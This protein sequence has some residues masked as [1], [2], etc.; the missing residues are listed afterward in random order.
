MSNDISLIGLLAFATLLPFLVA[1]GTCYLKFSI[2]FVIVGNALALQQVP[3]NL[4]V[5]AVA[6]MMSIFEMMPVVTSVYE[7]Q[8]EHPV[9]FSNRE[10]VREFLD[11]G[12]ADYR[13]YLQKHTDPKLTAFFS[14]IRAK[15]LE[16]SGD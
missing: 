2:V 13:N 10:S 16:E 6:L 8:L 11:A 12:L 4:V 15:N 3:S 1:A 14:N 9:N 5:N 7:Y